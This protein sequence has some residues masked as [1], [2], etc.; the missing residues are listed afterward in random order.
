MSKP[1]ILIVDDN[2]LNL[3]LLETKLHR[4]KMGVRT[5]TDGA[6]CLSM[7]KEQKPDL[8]L[9][10]I[11][12]PGMD[13]IEVCN[14]LRSDENTR[15]IPII[16]ITANSSREQKLE[17]LSAGAVDYITK[18]IDLDETMARVNTQ[19][20]FQKIIREKNVLQQHLLEARRQATVGAI[21]QGIAHNLNNLLG[22]AIGYLDLASVKKDDTESLQKAL[23]RIRQNLER[24]STIISQITLIGEKFRM[25]TRSCPILSLVQNSLLRIQ[26]E[27]GITLK[28]T[29]EISPETNAIHTNE[30][31][32][33]QVFIP[34]L[35]NA[36]ESTQRHQP[37]SEQA[38]IQITCFPDKENPNLMVFHI[39]DNGEGL[40]PDLKEDLFE[41][42]VSTKADVGVGMGLTIARHY[43]EQFG[44]SLTLASRGETGGAVATWMHPINPS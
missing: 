23:P 34:L 30:E 1:D 37:S 44:G 39:Y 26:Q 15:D 20:A 33:A 12:M 10:D 22:T 25:G 31:G 35:L 14:R 9:L 11:S 18:P 6:V 4:E 32:F 5:A 8:I 38:V 27:Y 21:S 36:W 42:F 2:L 41:P 28:P 16:F 13:G 40:D 3:K 43:A 17:G 19:L 24:I 7:V 29:L